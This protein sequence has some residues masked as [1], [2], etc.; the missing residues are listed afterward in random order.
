MSDTNDSPAY[1][2]GFSPVEQARLMKQ[3]R[4][5]ESTIFNH[6]DYTGARRLLEVGSGVG[7]QTEI[8][9]RRVPDVHV[10]CVDLSEVQLQAAKQNLATMPCTKR[11]C[12]SGTWSAMR[13]DMRLRQPSMPDA[14]DSRSATAASRT[15]PMA[16]MRCAAA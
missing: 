3:A 7:A 2:H 15:Y 12:R 14:G 9:L 1:L 5:L 6:I 8:L 11:A 10:S 4:L 13:A 16:L